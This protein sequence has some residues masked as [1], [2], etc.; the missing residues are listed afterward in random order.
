M[1]KDFE[2]CRS[3][4]E[5]RIKGR[6]KSREDALAALAKGFAVY[7]LPAGETVILDKGVREL[8]F[9]YAKEKYLPA[10]LLNDVIGLEAANQEIYPE[11]SGI[12]LKDGIFTAKFFAVKKKP[13]AN[14]KEAVYI[15][16]KFKKEGDGWLAEAEVIV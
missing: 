8:K 7:Q 12:S 16:S 13:G 14:P 11:V 5:I 1:E 15:G 2:I 9:G 10:D 3:G 6:G 4:A